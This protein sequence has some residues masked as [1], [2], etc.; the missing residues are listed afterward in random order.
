MMD[1][2]LG[3]AEN[4]A[5]RRNKIAARYPKQPCPGCGNRDQQQLVDHISKGDASWRC[6]VCRTQYHYEPL[7]ITPPQRIK[8]RITKLQK[9]GIALMITA[10]LGFAITLKTG[11]PVSP[12]YHV[13]AAATVTII[14]ELMMITGITLAWND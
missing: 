4:L 10:V 1:E 2:E 5:D 9:I 7:S 11:L 8:K 14:F 3:I 12:D 13:V 6:R